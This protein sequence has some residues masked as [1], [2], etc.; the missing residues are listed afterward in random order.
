MKR[1]K[2]R[3]ATVGAGF[4]SQFHYNGWQRLA[5]DDLVDLVA[6]CNRSRA[7]AEQFARQCDIPTTYDNFE[8]MIEKETIDLIDIITPPETHVQ[9]VSAAVDRGINV[10]C[11]KPFT[12]SL[13]QAIELN[14]YIANKQAE[15]FVHEDFRFQPWYTKIK[16]LLDSGE[17]GQLYQITFNLRPGDGQGENAYMDRQ[18]YFQ[19]MPKFL[20]HETA[21][22]LI[23]V[24]RYL[25]GEVSSVYAQ[26][27]RVNPV[28]AGEDAGFIL[29]TFANG[30]RGLF[31]GNR[32]SDH[33]ADN[34][35]LTMGEMRIEG[36]RGTLTLDGDGSLKL[37]K[38]G[39][40][41]IEIIEYEWSD[42]DFGG[43]CVYLTN[44]HIVDHLVFD[45]PVM[46]TAAEYLKNIVIEDAVY[47]SNRDKHAIQVSV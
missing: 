47:R 30:S 8:E 46:N 34:R 20:V 28:I 37:R 23:D 38:H 1:K 9:Y 36:E 31:D 16:A 26:L 35:R 15:V 45:S 3:V 7:N 42:R 17:L 40:N 43:D 22:H 33:K 14:E 11:Q 4:F 44:K 21:I 29:F 2:L 24:F 5:S 19:K 27:T 12:P 6:I 18:P 25:F 13:E 41:Q 10:I 32:C 39:S